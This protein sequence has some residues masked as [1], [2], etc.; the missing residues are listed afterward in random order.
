VTDVDEAVKKGDKYFAMGCEMEVR[1]VSGTGAWVDV[2]VTQPRTGATWNKRHLL[3]LPA[4]W[5]KVVPDEQFEWLP[6]W[7]IHPGVHWREIVVD[8]ELSQTALARQM[9]VSTKHLSQILTCAVMPGVEATLSFARAT[10][11]SPS[12][13][14][15][16]ACDHKLAMAMG[17]KD[18]TSDYL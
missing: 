14:W 16:L 11:V 7:T 17:K 5:E 13:L 6:D 1:R 9:G 4:D 10:G 8:Q 15:R 18:L 12:L 2:T 3:P